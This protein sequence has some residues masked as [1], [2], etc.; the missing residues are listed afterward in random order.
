M[1]EFS[2]NEKHFYNIKNYFEAVI[3]LIEGLT[4]DN[5]DDRIAAFSETLQ[6]IGNDDISYSHSLTEI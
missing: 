4:D 3:T 2:S 5:I 6:Y 1:V